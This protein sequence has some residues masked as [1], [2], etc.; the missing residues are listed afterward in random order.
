MK[1]KKI[2]KEAVVILI[3]LAILFS[4]IVPIIL[5]W[6]GLW[7]QQ[8]GLEAQETVRIVDGI[9]H[10]EKKGIDQKYRDKL[11]RMLKE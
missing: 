5:E 11:I 1:V 8:A 4:T 3:I 7:N 2:I 6:N 10:L 9:L